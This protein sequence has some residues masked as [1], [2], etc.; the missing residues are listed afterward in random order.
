VTGV[1]I[2]LDFKAESA[3]AALTEILARG[4]NL[5]PLMANIGASLVVS[6][7]HR[8][9]TGTGPSGEAWKP[10]IRAERDGG[11]T[12]VNTRR[13]L[14]SITF[15]ADEDSVEVGS[16]VLYS[17][18]HQFGGTIKAKNGGALHFHVAGKK[19]LVGAVKMPA[20]PF[21]GLSA[22]DNQKILDLTQDYLVGDLTGGVS[23][24]AS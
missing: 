4:A 13:L 22:A 7:Q 23:P 16:N 6:T 3:V 21:L 18:I 12:L 19:I 14:Q 9:E 15:S 5:A 8:F 11:L 2:T 20:R 24:V 17:A 1:S 10:S